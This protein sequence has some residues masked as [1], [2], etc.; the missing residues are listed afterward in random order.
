MKMRRSHYAILVS[1]AAAA[2]FVGLNL[3]AWR[4]LPGARAD[5]TA[6]GLYTLS[7]SAKRVVQRLIEPVE[8][9]FVYSRD[10]G[11]Q[12][13]AIRAHADRVRQLMAEIAAQSDG[14]VKIREVQPAPFSDEEDRI[15][16]AGITAGPTTS[17][18][19]LYFGVIGYNTSADVIAIPFL[20]PERDALLEYELVR[21]ISQLDDP[22]PPKVAVL[23]SLLPYQ[24]QASEAGSAFILR[25]GGRAY[26]INI[27]PADFRALPTGTDVLLMVHPP[28][29]DEWQ[30]YVI[31]QF[32]VHEGAALIA[33]DPV[34][35][36][37]LAQRDNTPAASSLGRLGRMF[38]LT[39]D[40][41]TVADETLALPVNVDIGGGRTMQVG[42]P[43]FPAPPPALMSQT[44][45]ITSDLSRAINF[46]A[47]GHLVLKPPVGVTVEPLIQTS[48][49]AAL[50][51]AALA[52]SDPQP[53]AVMDA[54]QP[55]GAQQVLAARVSGKFLSTFSDPPIP[56]ADVDPVVAELRRQEM[57]RMPPFA[58]QS[59]RAG[60]VI[61]IADTDMFDDS[62]YVHP[63]T[64]TALADN[65]AFVLNALDNLGGDPA[66]TELRSRAPAARPMKRV[67]DLRE[68][69]RTRLFAEQKRLEDVLKAAEEKLQALESRR[70]SGAAST[71]EELNEIGQYRTEA[72]DARRQLRG[73]EREFRS[74]IDAL[75]A[76]LLFLNVWLPPILVALAGLGVFAW[77][78]RRRGGAA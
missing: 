3:A 64:R 50:I 1:L 36:S 14:K 27:V 68:A 46:G 17:G 77:R 33:I 32:L 78:S 28:A 5:F 70:A 39:E 15:V 52:A 2:I 42:Q 69:A 67:D 18:E 38:G 23:S 56:Q 53:R 12:Y 72:A 40:A 58:S 37:A 34:S 21:L 6:N 49:K 7:S 61:L 71:P 30:S 57:A 41:E 65:A 75:E 43:L 25:E 19:P 11:A 31:D 54:Y 76:W 13:P 29:L 74:D 35:R 63:Q 55:A 9:E 22:A 51:P 45:V 44:D 60:D 73:V 48:A 4:W 66:L 59:V 10:V 62:F 26:E 8:L 20:A 24:L 16:A 47:P